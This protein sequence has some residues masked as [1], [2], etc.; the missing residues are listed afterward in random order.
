MDVTGTQTYGGAPGFA[1]TDD[2]PA[3]VTL[4]GTLVCTTVDGGLSVSTTLGVGHHTVDGTSCSGLTSSNSNYPLFYVGTTDGYGV[5]KDSSTIKLSKSAPFL[6]RGNEQ[7]VTLTA[8]VLTGNGE[9][10]PTSDSVTIGVGTT[11][12]VA[13]VAPAGGGGR[14]GCSIGASALPVGPFTATATYGGDADVSGSGPATTG[15]PVTQGS[16]DAATYSCVVSGFKTTTFPVF[17]SESPS[18]PTSIDAGG[19]FQTTMAAQMTVPA[20]V[21]AHYT[22]Q[23]ATSL[24]VSS[25]TT[26][27]NGLT[28]AGTP[29]GAV[30]P[31]TESAAATNLPQTDGVLTPNAPYAFGTTYNPVTWQTG[32]GTGVVNF[33]PGAIDVVVTFVIRGTPTTV[34]I[35]CTPPQGIGVLDSTTVLPPPPVPTFQVPTT[36]PPLQNQV[37]PGTDGGWA[38]QVSNTSTVTV[39]GLAATVS[40][41]DGGAALSYD[42]SGMAASGTNGCSATGPGTLSC[43]I[44]SLGAGSSKTVDVLV[45]TTGLGAGTTITGSIAVTSSNASGH[46]STFGAIQTVVVNNGTKA[47]AAPGVPLVS[48]KG[49]RFKFKTFITLTL[50]RQRI[51]VHKNVEPGP[52]LLTTPLAGTVLKAP[53]PVAVT[54]ETLAPSA[55]PAL[56]PPTGTLKCEGDIVQAEGNFSAYTNKAAPVIAVIKFFYGLRVPTGTV[57]MLKP[58]GKKVVK[59]A[60]CKKGASGYNTPCV[61]GKEK[62]LGSASHDSLYAQDTVYFT[63]VDPVMGRR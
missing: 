57:Y 19:T 37:S 44:G 22:A 14:G 7:A 63:G 10:L 32:P 26:T 35:D 40:V 8:T 39:T 48:T 62:I 16:T 17:V 34:S 6:S 3:G 38:V 61:Y 12:C 58:N 2:A 49:S 18:P 11:Q 36:T 52:L 59:L 20:S 53:P 24:T 30:D 56:C 5:S 25:Q 9:S 29:S 46:S 21:I 41:S 51:R 47:V 28:A 15:V 45:G 27:E 4:S 33:V 42:V 60:A 43:P 55:E 23:G 1:E 50:P 13:T 31:A 54:L